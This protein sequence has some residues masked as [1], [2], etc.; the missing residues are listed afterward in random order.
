MFRQSVGLTQRQVASV[1]NF[2]RLL[3]DARE[4]GLPSRQA[5]N[6]ALRDGRFDR[7]ILR[8][9][10][11]DRPLTNQQVE[12][13]VT[14]YRERYVQYRS[15]VIARTEAWRAVNQGTEEM[16]Q[17]AVDAG[18]IRPEQ[19]TRTWVTARDERVRSSHARLNGEQRGYNE[20]WQGD[21]GELRYPGDPLAPASETVQCRC[22][23]S[24]RLEAP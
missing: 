17:Q 8:A 6:R 15:E 16:Y 23:I 10:R 13:M 14:R 9:I 7:T 18:Q 21:N 20:T 11:E 4:D 19:M 5:L 24:T 1:N 3:T 22:R 12:R 2:R